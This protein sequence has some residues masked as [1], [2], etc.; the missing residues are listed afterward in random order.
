M[1]A[2]MVCFAAQQAPRSSVERLRSKGREDTRKT[3]GGEAVQTYRGNK[4]RRSDSRAVNLVSVNLQQQQSSCASANRKNS[5]KGIGCARA[6]THTQNGSRWGVQGAPTDGEDT[7]AHRSNGGLSRPRSPIR[8]Q[9]PRDGGKR[10]RWW[11][12][13][14][15]RRGVTT[16][17]RYTCSRLHR[18]RGE[19]SC[20]GTFQMRAL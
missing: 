15:C 19:P 4:G 6:N 7:A 1:S 13:G 11:G 18:G 8:G 14:A 17:V 5:E 9:T 20:T 3:E 2:W 16:T 10:G 12:R